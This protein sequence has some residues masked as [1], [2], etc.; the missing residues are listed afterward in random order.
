MILMSK[1]KGQHGGKTGSKN[2][3]RGLPP[4]PFRAMPKRKH[5][6]FQ[7]GFPKLAWRL[8]NGGSAWIKV[9]SSQDTSGGMCWDHFPGP[10]WPSGGAIGPQNGSKLLQTMCRCT[11]AVRVAQLPRPP[12]LQRPK[13]PERCACARLGAVSR[14]P[15]RGQDAQSLVGV[16]KTT[17]SSEK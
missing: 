16:A 3:G 6:F 10:E 12:S 8:R 5:F 1:Y 17:E 13:L 4:P 14:A 2:S 15:F 7:E 11:F 9:G